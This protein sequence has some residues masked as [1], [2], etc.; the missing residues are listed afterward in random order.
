VLQQ[1][2]Q[3]SVSAQQEGACQGFVDSLC[4]CLGVL[5]VFTSGCADLSQAEVADIG[6]QLL[7]VGFHAVL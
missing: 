5:L 6:Q 1:R 4:L 7:G 2:Q 3:L